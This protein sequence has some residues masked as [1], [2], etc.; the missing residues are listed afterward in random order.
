MTLRYGLRPRGNIQQAAYT[1]DK[2]G[3]VFWLVYDPPEHRDTARASLNANHKCHRRT[4]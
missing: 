1:C 4:T 3:T 2:C